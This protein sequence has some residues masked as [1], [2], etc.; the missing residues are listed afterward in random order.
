[1][2]YIPPWS[3]PCSTLQNLS[4]ALWSL[5]ADGSRY[6]VVSMGMLSWISSKLLA[7]EFY[8]SSYYHTSAPI[9]LHLLKEVPKLYSAWLLSCI[10]GQI[11]CRQP[12]QRDRV[13][14][15]VERCLELDT[16]LDPLAAVEAR[17]RLLEVLVVVVGT[18]YVLPVLAQVERWALHLDPA[19][20]RHFA[21]QLLDLVA[22][23]YSTAFLRPMVRLLALGITAEYL[24]SASDASKQPLNA[25]LEHCFSALADLRSGERVALNQL[26]CSMSAA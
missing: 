3:P 1:M 11:S 8:S 16:D 6:P 9:Y 15:L 24:R 5:L 2:R 21:L 14:R 20:V 23:P 13:L 22:P 7:R 25:F 17:K 10:S 18:G 4:F 26:K 12:P 19:L